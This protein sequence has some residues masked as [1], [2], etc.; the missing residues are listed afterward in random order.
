[1]SLCHSI[2]IIVFSY[3][4]YPLCSSAASK[5]PAEQG[6]KLAFE[7][8]NLPALWSAPST[9]SLLV[10]ELGFILG[11]VPIDSI[12]VLLLIF[13]TCSGP[14]LGSLSSATTQILN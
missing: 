4:H 11:F 10:S 7:A 14:A 6:L 5:G 1:M 13:V 3:C 2:L 12:P 8:A 9:G